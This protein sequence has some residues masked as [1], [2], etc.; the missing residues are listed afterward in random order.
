M[1]T[2]GLSRNLGASNV[3]RQTRRRLLHRVMLQTHRA[4]FHPRRTHL[5]SD[6]LSVYRKAKPI[7]FLAFIQPWDLPVAVD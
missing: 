4:H 1:T 3:S 6:P 7:L 5:G 2:R